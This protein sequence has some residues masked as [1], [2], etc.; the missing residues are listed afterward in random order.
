ME[1]ADKRVYEGEQIR[2]RLHNTIMELKGNIRVFCRVRPVN[3]AEQVGS[4]GYEG[5]CRGLGDEERGRTG[6]LQKG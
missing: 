1:A 4:V 2:R 6:L 3:G 5:A